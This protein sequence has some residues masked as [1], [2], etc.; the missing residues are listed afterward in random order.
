MSD[1]ELRMECLRLA[2][3]LACRSASEPNGLILP[4]ADA[5][6]GYVRGTPEEDA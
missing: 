5:L 3:S 4:M 6:V 1:E 2:V